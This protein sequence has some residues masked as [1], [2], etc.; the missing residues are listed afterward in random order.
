MIKEDIEIK[1]NDK[2]K[3]TRICD[4]CGRNDIV[5]LSSIWHSRNIRKREK[6]LCRSCS[7]KKEFFTKPRKKRESNYKPPINENSPL[8][9]GGI[10]RYTGYRKRND[11]NGKTFWEHRLV[12]SESLGRELKKE[13]IVH[14]I[15]LDKLNN[16]LDNLYLFSNRRCHMKAHDSLEKCGREFLKK[17]IWFCF[18][19]NKYV[20]KKCS[21]VMIDIDISD[22]LEKKLYY[23]TDPRS[24]LKYAFLNIRLSAN[25]WKW[26]RFHVAIAERVIGRSLTRQ[27]CVH[28]IDLDTLNNDIENLR[29]M[30]IKQHNECHSSLESCASK[31]FKEGLINFN[32]DARKYFAV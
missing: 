13:E 4:G 22:L 24:K 21:S 27:E 10:D 7:S 23:M 1:W 20:M 28:H 9:K 26:K 15:D 31:L 8:W 14:H 3:V 18:K 25:N 2:V 6:D 12:V 11:G 32:R 29:V 5:K 30:T 17:K 16:S 19:N